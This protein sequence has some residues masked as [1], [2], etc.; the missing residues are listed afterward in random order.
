CTPKQIEI[1]P[2]F[3]AWDRNRARLGQFRD[4]FSNIQG[5]GILARH[6]LRFIKRRVKNEERPIDFV[7]TRVQSATKRL[8]ALRKRLQS[9]HLPPTLCDEFEKVRGLVDYAAAAEF[10]AQ[11]NLVALL[12]RKSSVFAEFRKRLKRLKTLEDRLHSKQEATRGW[13]QK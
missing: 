6:P 10:L 7:T 3:A 11:L 4:V 13:R 1:V 9:S 5:D 12:D 8:E 2:T